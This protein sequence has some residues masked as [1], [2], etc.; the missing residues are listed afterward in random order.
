[1]PKLK[2]KS[3]TSPKT[4]KN[5]NAESNKRLA[6]LIK[7]IRNCKDI[8]ANSNYRDRTSTSNTKRQPN[9]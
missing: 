2:P 4:N 8:S 3:A 5:M 6:L 9:R 1:M 7:R